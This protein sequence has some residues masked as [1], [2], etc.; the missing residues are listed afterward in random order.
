LS[1]SAGVKY[2]LVRSSAFG[3]LV[4]VT[5]RFSLFGDDLEV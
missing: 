2:S 1:I 5:F 4:G 3:A